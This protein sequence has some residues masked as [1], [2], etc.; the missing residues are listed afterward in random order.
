[1][2]WEQNVPGNNWETGQDWCWGDCKTN[3]QYERFVQDGKEAVQ[4]AGSTDCDKAM[5]ELVQEQK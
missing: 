2:I 5:D 3:C 4:Q 1:M